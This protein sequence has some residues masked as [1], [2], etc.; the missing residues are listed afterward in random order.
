MYS[1]LSSIAI[2][3]AIGLVFGFLLTHFCLAIRRDKRERLKV[4]LEKAQV[5]NSTQK[6]RLEGL[7]RDKATNLEALS[8]RSATIRRQ[9]D[10]LRHM[11]LL[12]TDVDRL[13]N[14][15][16][17]HQNTMERAE[18]LENSNRDI[19]ANRDS[20]LQ[21]QSEARAAITRLR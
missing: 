17:T 21:S 14:E 18:R 11:A 1:T 5:T 6:R 16:A 3:V 13:R 7:E 8:E 20:L 10:R 9:E 15:A 19:R 2:G 12:Q 4:D